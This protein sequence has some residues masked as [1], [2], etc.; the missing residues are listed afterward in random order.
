MNPGSN[1]IRAEYYFDPNIY[2]QNAETWSC[3]HLND[4]TARSADWIEEERLLND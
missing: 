1:S 2:Q 3:V 4:Y